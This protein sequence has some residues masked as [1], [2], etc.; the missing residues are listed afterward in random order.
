MP[1]NVP[2]FITI[3]DALLR[4]LKNQL[5]EADT[6]S[7]SDYFIRATSVASAVEGLYQHQAWIVRQIFPDTADRDYLELHARVRG[8]SR[9]SAVAARGKIKLTGTPGST[10]PAGLTAKSST[11]TYVTTEAGAIGVDGTYEIAAAAALA[12]GAGNAAEGAAL[13]LTSAPSGVVSQAVIVTMDGGVDEESDSELLA[14][15][16]ELIRRPPAGG[17]K[18]DYR[19]WALEVP[20]VAA[21]YVYPMRRGIGTVDIVITTIDG[22]PSEETIDKVQA[23][24]DD[25]RPVTAKSS[26]V[27]AP[28]IKTVDVAVKV[29]LSGTTQDAIKPQIEEALNA[30]FNQLVPGDS[31][32]KSRIE[33]IISDLNG[34]VDRAVSQPTGNIDAEVTPEHVE[35]V[36]LGTVTV[37]ALA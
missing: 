25:V 7:D 10:V 18:Y 36:R 9:K 31:A 24:I 6:G 35:W 3:R 22:V 21:A 15:L 14:R 11:Q 37:E 5:P 34:V 4:D 29:K 27:M 8:L 12:G 19:R 23:Y 20:G 16:L 30:Y 32:I 2:T 33:A 26:L 28:D 13:E 1:F 17:N